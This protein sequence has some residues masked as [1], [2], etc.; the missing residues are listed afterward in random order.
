VL[1]HASTLTR[2]GGSWQVRGFQNIVFSGHAQMSAD[3]YSIPAVHAL[4][5]VT[6]VKRWDVGADDLLAPLG[7][8]E[9]A[10][11]APDARLSI[12][13][14]EA[15]VDRA[16]TLTREP[17]LGLHL[18]LQMSIAS[19]GYLGFAAMTAATVRQALDL[20]IR[21]VPTRT[22]ALRLRLH[23]EGAQAALVVEERAPLGTVRDVIVLAL[24]VGI[25]Q[26]GRSVTGR[27]LDGTMELAFPEPAYM[28]RFGRFGG[29]VRFDQPAH[30]L[31]FDRAVL[32]LPL[33]NADPVAMQ[34]ARAQCERELS[35]L[36]V[37]HGE[38]VLAAVERVVAD[39]ER[40]FRSLE[41]V[42]RTLHLSPRTLK[43][44][45]AAE[46]ATFSAIVEAARRERALLLLRSPELSL[47]EIA[48]RLGYSDV[49][50]FTRAFRRWTGR[51]PGAFRRART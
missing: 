42:A 17:G 18:G 30:Q 7:H 27:D 28:A 51:T 29:R 41:D 14:L 10:F 2:R 48:D 32:D 26:M 31:V 8:S 25:W 39:G 38:R 16:R 4:H 37:A 24:L 43:R 15:L 50:N 21:F 3:A 6:L 19:H 22:A 36:D 35:L 40:G 9:A 5:L 23:E 33:T 20:A 47:D 46:G 12:A 11:A 45:L 44:R 1:I 13:E 34:L 49:A